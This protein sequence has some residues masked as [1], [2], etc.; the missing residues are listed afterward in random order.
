MS[1]A[2]SPPWSANTTVSESPRP[3]TYRELINSDQEIYGGSGIS[4]GPVIN[5]LP[6]PS[7]TFGNTLSLV[8]PPLSTL[9]LQPCS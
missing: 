4:N 5:T 7:H 1:S 6:E 8:L 3:G 2:I 9:F